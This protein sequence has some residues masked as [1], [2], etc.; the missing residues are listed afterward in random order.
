MT[1]WLLGSTAKGYRPWTV[2]LWADRRPLGVGAKLG[3]VS[4]SVWWSER[5]ELT[6]TWHGARLV[7]DSYLRRLSQ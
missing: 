6:V 1:L 2:A 3:P 7:Y 4:V 5:P